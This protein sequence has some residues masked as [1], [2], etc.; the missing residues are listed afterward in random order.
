M[1]QMREVKHSA[2]IAQPPSRLFALIS[3]IESYPLFLPW[4]THA[5]VH[6]RGPREMLASIA[7]QRGPLKGELTTRNELE[8]H[9]RILMHLVNGPLFRMLEG[10][11][12]LTPIGAAGCRV[13]L[14]LR[15]SF[16][17]A[18]SGVLLEPIFAETAASLVNAFVGRSQALDRVQGLKTPAAP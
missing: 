12:L 2:F 11:W 5:R 10:E 4:C 15:F 1:L 14:T 17:N 8:P 18:L 9:R 6:S 7:M 3:D 13:D 16:R